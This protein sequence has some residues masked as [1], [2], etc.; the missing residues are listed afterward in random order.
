MLQGG[1]EGFL[2]LNHN[3]RSSLSFVRYSLSAL[4]K[5]G[6]WGVEMEIYTHLMDIDPYTYTLRE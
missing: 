2:R 4:I 1:R 6:D 5:K 3:M